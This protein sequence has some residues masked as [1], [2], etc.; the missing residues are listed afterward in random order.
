MRSIALHRNLGP[1]TRVQGNYCARRVRPATA[2]PAAL[3]FS[4]SA[5]RAYA[6]SPAAAQRSSSSRQTAPPNSLWPTHLGCL[7]PR[8]RG[9]TRLMRSP[10]KSP[11]L[12]LPLCRHH[13]P[14]C[15]LPRARFRFAMRRLP[16]TWLWECKRC[17]SRGGTPISSL[18][19]VC[20]SNAGHEYIVGK[21]LS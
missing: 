6:G 13:H 10:L 4:S 3:T 21:P 18:W 5:L 19:R 17:S 9:C 1:A 7:P 20:I 12:S 8:T 14:S 11:F 15:A 16:K 2:S